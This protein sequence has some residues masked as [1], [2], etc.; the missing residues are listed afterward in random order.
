MSA[1]LIDAQHLKQL[2][3]ADSNLLIFDVRANLSDP[4][5]G[6]N[7]YKQAHIPGAFH[8]DIQTQLSGAATADSGRHP[9]PSRSH[10]LKLLQSLGLRP[11]RPV[12]VYDANDSSFAARLWWLLRWLGHEQVALLNGGWQAWL[13]ADGPSTSE[14]SSNAEMVSSPEGRQTASSYPAKAQMPT[15]EMGQLQQN[16]AEPNLLLIDARSAERFRG[17][18]EPIDPVAGHIPGARNRPFIANLDSN[19]RFKAPRQLRHEF[20]ELITGFTPENVVHQCGSGVTACHNLFAMELAG[21]KGSA[22][23]PG[24]FSQ[25]CQVATNPI[26]K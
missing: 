16:I 13:E 15:I 14:G 21:L 9:L 24:S 23:Y 10:L 19:Y 6:I 17:E 18:I 4:S 7:A 2:L 8:L 5:A 1:R 11:G 12:V 22:L 26:S 20:T 25:W 3:D